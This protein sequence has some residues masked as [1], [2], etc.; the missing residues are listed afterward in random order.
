MLWKALPG[1]PG[2]PGR[3]CVGAA[4]ESDLLWCH[5]LPVGCHL[6]SESQDPHLPNR[7]PGAWGEL[8]RSRL[9]RQ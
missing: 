2:A 8:R 7:D 9:C 6:N 5:L 3:G 1:P 4:V